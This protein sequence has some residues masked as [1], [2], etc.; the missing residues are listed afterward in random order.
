VGP[1]I[2]EQMDATTLIGPGQY[3]RLDAYRNLHIDLDPS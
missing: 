3:A 2:V 1:A